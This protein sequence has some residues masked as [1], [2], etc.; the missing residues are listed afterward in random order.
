MAR[1][2]TSLFSIFLSS[3]IRDQLEHWQRSTTIQTGLAKCSQTILWRT[4]S[5]ALTEIAR[6]LGVGW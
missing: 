3:V 2:C 1:G 6:R 5:L 4:Y